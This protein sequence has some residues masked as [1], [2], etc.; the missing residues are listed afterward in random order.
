M[1]PTEA[2]ELGMLVRW[3]AASFFGLNVFLWKDKIHSET[4]INH[5]C[6]AEN[7]ARKLNTLSRQH[8]D[9]ETELD[10]PPGPHLIVTT[11]ARVTISAS[12]A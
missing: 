4:C 2:A 3:A 9:E 10:Q 7:D 11:L 6:S 8:P 5:K 1:A 12:V